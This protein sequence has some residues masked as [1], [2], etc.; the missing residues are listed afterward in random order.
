MNHAFENL[1]WPAALHKANAKKYKPEIGRGCHDQDCPMHVRAWTSD[2]H[3][4]AGG[5]KFSEL[6]R[7]G[8]E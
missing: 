6:C 3:L 5:E 4:W 7:H 1:H 2:T 8:A